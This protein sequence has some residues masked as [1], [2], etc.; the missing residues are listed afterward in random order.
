MSK[1]AQAGASS[2]TPARPRQLERQSHRLVHRLRPR[3]PARRRASACLDQRPRLADGDDRPGSAAERFAQQTEIAA[4]EPTT[5]DRH[6]P[7][8]R[9][10]QSTAA[11]TRRWSPSSRSRTGRRRRSAT[12]SIACSRPR[13]RFDRGGHGRRRQRRPSRRPSPP[14]SRRPPGAGRADESRRAAPGARLPRSSRLTIHPS[15]SR[16][17]SS[18]GR[19]SREQPARAARPARQVA[20]PSDRRR[21]PRPSR[22]AAGFRRSAPS[23]PHTPRR[24]DADRDGR[25]KN[26]ASP[27]S[28]DGTCRSAPVESCSSRR[29]A[30]CSASIPR[31][32]RSAARRCFR[33]PSRRNPRASSI[34]PV[35]AV[36]VDFPFVPVIAITR[37]F[38]HRD[39]SSTSPITGMPR[40]RAAS[41]ARLLRRHARARH[42]QIGG[43][44]RR[45]SGG[46]RVRARRPRRRAAAP[47]AA[48]ACASD[49]VTRAPRLDQQLR[50]GHPASRGADHHHA[51]ARNRQLPLLRP[52]TAASTSSG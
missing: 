39:A 3:G 44:E 51:L 9:S 6:Q 24:S 41:T 49:S 17:P 4:L 13:K 31:P 42:H 27:Q 35:S 34:R 23:P 28:T 19:P 50:G 21:S 33:R 30:A 5:D 15:R 14:P 47:P 46:R 12:S 1:L 52:V 29:R 43:R 37:P 7:A 45:R 40:A 18:S 8:R 22:P 36:V 26:S 10:S 38:S 11:P 16:V 2:T 32:A 25:A 48:S 20:A